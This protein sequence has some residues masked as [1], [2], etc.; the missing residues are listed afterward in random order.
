MLLPS[1]KVRNALQQKV[2]EK[3]R[4]DDDL[5]KLQASGN[6]KNRIL[7][8]LVTNLNFRC[9]NDRMILTG[10]ETNEKYTIVPL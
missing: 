6:A 5:Q 1:G 2:Q 9:S 8:C 3:W 4:I 7:E 10:I